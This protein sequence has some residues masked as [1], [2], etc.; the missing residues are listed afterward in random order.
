MVLHRRLGILRLVTI[1]VLAAI[2][3]FGFASSG[4][5]TTVPLS[6]TAESTPQGPSGGES[7][8]TTEL[9]PPDLPT[10]NER[11]FTF[12]LEVS[13]RADL[14]AVVRE[15]AVYELRRQDATKEQTEALVE[16]L[17]IDADVSDRGDGSFEAS[18][19]GQ[20]YV[21]SDLIQFFSPAPA[22]DGPLPGDEEAIAFGRDWLRIIGL[23]PPDLGEG[24]VVSRIEETKRV[25]VLYGPAEPRNVLAA[26]PSIAVTVGPAGVVLEASLR[27]ASVIRIDVYQLMPA[28]QAWQLIESGQAY[29]EADIESDEIEPGAEIKGRA[30][31]NDVSIAYATSGPPGGQQYL[32]PIYVFAGTLR[33]DDVDGSFP[34]KAYLPALANSG[35]PVGVMPLEVPV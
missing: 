25:I 24:R 34:I 35:A 7:E 30:T 22:G 15:A 17:G 26:Y 19:N 12:N 16:K 1:A 18:G 8:V 33:V 13:L 29:L 10:S 9:P 4:N 3:Y 14:D 5:A 2:S 32:Q 6:P 11:G 28:R 27:W 21:S 23:L 31:F 20:L